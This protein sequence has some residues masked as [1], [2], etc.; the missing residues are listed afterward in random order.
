MDDRAEPNGL[1]AVPPKDAAE[2]INKQK[3]APPETVQHTLRRRL[4]IFSFWAVVIFLGL[5]IWWRTTTV[6]RATLPLQQML[7]WSDGI[8]CLFALSI[9]TAILTSA[10]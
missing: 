6:Y 2:A 9:S 3:S 1:P 10:A 8:V 5:P 7:D 4:I